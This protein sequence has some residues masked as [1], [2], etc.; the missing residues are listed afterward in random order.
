MFQ[1][2][3]EVLVIILGKSWIEDNKKTQ[4]PIPLHLKNF[5]SRHTFIQKLI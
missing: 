3:K 4:N 5:G 1:I 2:K